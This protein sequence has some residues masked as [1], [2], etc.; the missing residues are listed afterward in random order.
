MMLPD[1]VERNAWSYLKEFTDARIAIGRSGLSIPT[2]EVLRFQLSHAQA[3]DAVLQPLDTQKLYDQLEAQGIKFMAVH[4]RVR[5]RAQYLR[6]PDLGRQLDADGAEK[7]AAL[8]AS[9]PARPDVALV[10]SE[11]LSSIA[12]QNNLVPFLKAFHA[13]NGLNV[14]F[15]PLV[16][17]E[18]GRVAAADAVSEI[19]G[20][21]VTVMFIGERPGLSSPDSMGIYMTYG[22]KSGITDERRNCISNIRPAGL[23][24]MHAADT[25]NYLLSESLRRGLSG[26]DLKDDQVALE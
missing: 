15:S 4:S 18:Q 6:R 22:A 24:Y 26:V 8:A 19:L 14:R 20:A 3:R 11:G 17:V 10:F 9:M 5:D 23:S 2:R 21:T 16:H 25:L 13:V 12:I 7:L 1:L